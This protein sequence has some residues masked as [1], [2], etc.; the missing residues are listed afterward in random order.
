MEPC[1]L[2]VFTQVL[3]VTCSLVLGKLLNFSVSL[4]E[5]NSVYLSSGLMRIKEMVRVKRLAQ[6]K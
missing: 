1:I 4:S 3:L 5:V 6:S 2:V